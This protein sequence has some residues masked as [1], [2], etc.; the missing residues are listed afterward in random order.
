MG[1][2]G[3]SLEPELAKQYPFLLY[4]YLGRFSGLQAGFNGSYRGSLSPPT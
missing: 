4:I 1:R 3:T 2:Q